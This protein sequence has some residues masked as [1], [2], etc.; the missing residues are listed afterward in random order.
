MIQH[1]LRCQ[2]RPGH[3]N[4][5]GDEAHVYKDGARE[6]LW[7]GEPKKVQDDTRWRFGIRPA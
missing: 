1:T 5:P 6:T 3:E 7:F 2:K 4:N